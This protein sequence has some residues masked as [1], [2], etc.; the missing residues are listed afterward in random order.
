MDAFAALRFSQA[1]WKYQQMALDVVEEQAAFDNKYHIVAPPGSGKTVVG[2]ELIR[3][4]GKPAVVFAPT[5]TIQ[6]QW[7]EKVS[8]F[9]NDRGW[10]V[11]HTSLNAA[12]L[13]TVNFLTYQILSTPG[14]NLAFVEQIAIERWVDDLLVSGIAKTRKQACQRVIVLQEVNPKAFRKEVSNRY[15]KAKRE[16]LQR[17]DFDGQQF[18]HS[19]ARDLIDR[20]VALKVATVVLDECHHLLD[21]WAFIL[22]ELIKAL[23][24]VRIIGLTATLPDPQNAAEYEN[25]TSLLGEV[26]FEIP[27][28]AVVKEGNLAPYRDLVYFC[29][30]SLRENQYLRRIQIHFEEAI[31]HVSEW[32]EFRFWVQDTIFGGRPIG[33]APRTQFESFE[34]LFKQEP[35]LCIA[36][37]K[38]V[39]AQRN[40]FSQG[41]P[42]LEE[43]RQPM[44]IDDWLVL[45]G[46]F[47]LRVLKVDPDQQTRYRELRQAL[48]PFGVALTERGVRRNR[49][50]TDLVLA[51]SESKDTA[52]VKILQTEADAIRDRL[53]AVVI[54]DFERMGTRTRRLKDVLDS[55]AG[56]AIRVFRHL[57]AD[58]KTNELDPILVTGKTVLVDADSRIKLEAGIRQWIERNH[59]TFEWTW[60]SMDDPRILQLLGSGKDWSSRTYVALVTDLF[61][62]AITRCLVGTRG[63]F[64]EGWDTL[65]LNTLI[66]LTSVTSRISVQQIRGRSL[67]LDP[68]WAHKVAHNWSV[69]C[70]SKEFDKGDADLR[71]FV[72]RHS[73]TWGVVSHSTLEKRAR[74]AMTQKTGQPFLSTGRVVKGVAHIDIEL[75]HDLQTSP[76]KAIDLEK[77]TREML[78]AAGKRSEVYALWGVGAPYSNAVYDV[79][80]IPPRDLTFRSARTVERSVQDVSQRLLSSILSLVGALIV[81]VILGLSALGPPLTFVLLAI[82]VI[83]A[84]VVTLFNGWKISRTVH[85]SFIDVPVNDVLLDIGQA[86]LQTLKC[87][88]VG[89]IS[90]YLDEGNIGVRKDGE[91]GDIQVFLERASRQ[92][93]RVFSQAFR[94][95]V[96]PIGDAR[97]L[98]ER[99]CSALSL[100]VH[101]RLWLRI[102][103]QFDIRDEGL[104]DYHRVPTVLAS[105]S[106]AVAF[107]QYWA[108]YVGGGR[109]IY[110]RT[111]EG[112]RILLQ[113]RTRQRKQIRQ[114]IFETWR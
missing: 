91:T 24:D 105:K 74:M 98:I 104:R 64:G 35:L 95:L 9:V 57:I 21:Y 13:A 79:T 25:Y 106:R 51:L 47:A 11:E 7:Q 52:T 99:D 72:T 29:K 17:D 14:E 48:L 65:G 3:R 39:L 100:S 6:K 60:G 108:Q 26:D 18:L 114:I 42:V 86:L 77:Y 33:T 16:L 27:T 113:A 68:S 63:I 78:D 2:L 62:Q 66:D 69:I 109:L 30:P 97:Y 31:Q 28:P 111:E 4:F 53:R 107:A 88:E 44:T 90:H 76:F 23:P 93:S 102:R 55:N 38:F 92:D 32:P 22:R 83:V 20:L 12:R 81:Q 110:T 45:L 112:Q 59:V 36:G 101:Q 87:D 8:L 40:M 54:T 37:A 15:R 10:I 19:N 80:Q 75:A 73:H 43:F 34:S 103:K 58:P 50:P 46:A 5:T 96:G 41:I 84:A 61:E 49:S 94:E 1:F 71:R 89:L 82:G 70:Y 85:R 67:R 56:S